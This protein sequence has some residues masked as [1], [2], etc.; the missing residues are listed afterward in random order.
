[1]A[2]YE[3]IEDDSK[4]PIKLIRFIN[5]ISGPIEKHWH[6]SIEIVV[7]LSGK[8][9]AW[10]DGKTYEYEGMNLNQGGHRVFVIN[11]QS[12]HSFESYD[13]SIPYYG[14][15]L[16]INYKFLKSICPTIDQLSFIERPDYQYSKKIKEMIWQLDEAYLCESHYKNALIMSK[17]YE[18]VYYL[19]ENISNKK[20]N[21]IENRSVKNKKR[22]T[23]IVNYIDQHY[24]D[25][26]HI[27]DIAEH[28]SMSTN[29]LS[30]LFKENLNTTVKS[31]LTSVRIKCAKK[32][33]LETDLPLID[34][35]MVN[36]F[37]N[38]KSLNRELEKD[39]QMSATQYRKMVKKSINYVK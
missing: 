32:Y 35:A 30:K 13:V 3:K 11:S 21:Y 10:I 12:I 9:F 26:L 6:N 7:P 8:G 28:F 18:I 34:V 19:L 36:G 25:D 16:Q 27:Q 1:M 33:L 39:C 5:D 2:K 4:L 23:E 31:Y 29:Q 24:Q 15:A 14:Y 37:P 22:I 17:L 38:L 20:E